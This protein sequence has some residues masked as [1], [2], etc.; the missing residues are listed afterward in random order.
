MAGRRTVAEQ[1]LSP[2]AAGAISC[3]WTAGIIQ[4]NNIIYTNDSSVQINTR[5]LCDVERFVV[6]IWAGA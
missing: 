6:E 3:G 5:S 4:S 1:W 2:P